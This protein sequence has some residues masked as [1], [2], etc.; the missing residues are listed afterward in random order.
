M[1]KPSMLKDPPDKLSGVFQQAK[2]HMTILKTTHRSAAMFCDETNNKQ[3]V[4]PFDEAKKIVE[5]REVMVLGQWC[6]LFVQETKAA[7][8][9]KDGSVKSPALGSIGVQIRG[10]FV[11]L[12]KSRVAPTTE[13]KPKTAKSLANP[14]DEF[15]D[16][17]DEPSDDE[18]DAALS[19][20]LGN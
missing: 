11:D 10:L 15:G 16:D 6:P 4:Y 19:A 14:A 13:S 5:G 8:L 18:S 12:G 20:A 9:N 3:K 2:D 17:S 7:V 1:V